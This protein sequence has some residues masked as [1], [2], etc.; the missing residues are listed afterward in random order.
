MAGVARPDWIDAALAVMQTDQSDLVALLARH[1]T[2]ACTD[3]TGFG[4]LGHLSEMLGPQG[5]VELDPAAIPA[6]AGALELLERGFASTLAPSNAS[7]LARLEPEGAVRLAA[8]GSA[9]TLQLLI[10]P[11]TCGPLL[12]AL[13]AATAPSALAELRSC[14]FPQAALIGRVQAS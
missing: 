1:G 2:R 6:F 11:Q 10:D 8:G 9:A 12:A 7:A 14:G 4:L 3:I 5:V 13:P